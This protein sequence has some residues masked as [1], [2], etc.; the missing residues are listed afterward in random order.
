MGVAIIAFI[1]IGG[2]SYKYTIKPLSQI[3]RPLEDKK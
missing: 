3:T 1:I 2:L